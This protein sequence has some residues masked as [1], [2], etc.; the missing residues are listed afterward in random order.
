MN[1]KIFGLLLVVVSVSV[2]CSGGGGGGG[3]NGRNTPRTISDSMTG[4]YAKPQAYNQKAVE[5]L[6]NHAKKSNSTLPGMDLLLSG[7]K[8][9]DAYKKLD[10]KG[11]D[12]FAKIRDNCTISNPPKKEDSS[13]GPQSRT[14][15]I[16]GGADC[17]IRYSKTETQDVRAVKGDKIITVTGT[18]TQ[19]QSTE[20]LDP[21][22]QGDTDSRKMTMRLAMTLQG[23]AAHDGNEVTDMVVKANGAGRVDAETLDGNVTGDIKFEMIMSSSRGGQPSMQMVIVA[24]IHTPEGSVSLGF[25]MQNQTMEIRVGGKVV[26]PKEFEEIFGGI[27]SGPTGLAQN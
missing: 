2:G 25:K 5:Y 9:A 20:I 17:P 14:E 19:E 23:D 7:D 24:M 11:K 21:Q 13:S 27:P 3:G 8:F 26:T 6:S 15:K 1:A 10:A 16:S 18:Q 22:M 12:Y 4:E